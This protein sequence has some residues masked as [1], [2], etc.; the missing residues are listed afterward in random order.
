MK[1][2]LSR[3]RR[4]ASGVTAIEFALVAPVL[5]LMVVGIAQMG[6]IFY[7]HAALRNAVSEGARYATIHPRPTA[8]QVIARIQEN[9]PDSVPGTYGTPVVTYSLNGTT[10]YWRANVSMRYTATFDFAVGKFSMNFDYSRQA[11][12]YPSATG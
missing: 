5:I 6:A 10:G 4:N 7:G 9:Q 2:F 3:L 1:R 12:V 11:N 8:A